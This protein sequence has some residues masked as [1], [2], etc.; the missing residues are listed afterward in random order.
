MDVVAEKIG[1]EE[2]TVIGEMSAEKNLTSSMALASSITLASSM[3]RAS[4]K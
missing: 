3:A 4:M 1:T 2:N